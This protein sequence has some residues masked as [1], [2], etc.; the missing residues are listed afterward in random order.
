LIGTDGP[1]DNVLKIRPP[2]SFDIAAADCLITKLD[3]A[4]AAEA[5][6]H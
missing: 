5:E 4:L 1:H 3:K 2:M 6:H